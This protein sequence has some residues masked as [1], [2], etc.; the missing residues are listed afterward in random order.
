MDFSFPNVRLFERFICKHVLITFPIC[1]S[2]GRDRFRSRIALGAILALGVISSPAAYAAGDPNRGAAS[3]DYLCNHCHGT[4]QPNDSAAFKAY[5]KTANSLSLYASNPAAI[6]KAINA[7]YTIPKGNTNDDYEPG[8]STA[9]AM[10]SFVG[11]GDKRMGVGET[12]TQY[13]IDISA[14]LATYFEVPDV[15]TIGTVAAGNGQATVSFKAPKSDL[16]V[17]NYTVTANPGGIKATGSTSPITVQGLTS[18]VAYTFTVTATSNAGTGKP[19]S[20]SNVVTPAAAIQ[21][22]AARVAPAASAPIAAPTT[23]TAVKPA[24]AA[25]SAPVAV[26]KAATAN[27]VSA[28]VVPAKT[29]ASVAPVVASVAQGAVA[30]STGAPANKVATTQNPPAAATGNLPATASA[31][32]APTIVA[33]KP[34]SAEARVFF[35]VPQDALA[36]IS[37]YTVVAYSGGKP[38]GIYANGAGSPIKITG[39]TNGTDYVFYVFSNGKSGVRVPSAASNVVTPLSIFGD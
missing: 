33:A 36:L 19:S 28:V 17:T 37:S 35:T 4:P 14:Y 22:V 13:A 32:P 34:G 6:T 31:V 18:G 10:G 21:A 23:V 25:T 12:P 30:S 11:M 8:S 27:A 7:G 20:A 2:S 1:F 16:P 5:G 9:L 26:A 39:L 29:A 38:T 24:P 3:W 15:P